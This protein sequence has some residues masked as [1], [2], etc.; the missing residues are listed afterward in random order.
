M[1]RPRLRNAPPIHLPSSPSPRAFP[2]PRVLCSSYAFLQS[3]RTFPART[4][5]PMGGSSHLKL[6]SQPCRCRFHWPNCHLLHTLS[7]STWCEPP[8]MA[9]YGWPGEVG[10]GAGQ[11][12][13]WWLLTC[14]HYHVGIYVLLPRD[15]LT[16]WPARDAARTCG[17]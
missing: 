2:C 14:Q 16:V 10:L 12:A 3:T 15:L 6:H 11:T 8:I 17:P 9:V 4:S 5:R 1:R 13:A 7:P